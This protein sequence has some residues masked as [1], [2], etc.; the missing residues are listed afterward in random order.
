MQEMYNYEEGI[1]V[2][3]NQVITTYILDENMNT[4]ISN[5]ILLVNGLAIQ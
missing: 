3:L 2:Q 1:F 5:C 4:F